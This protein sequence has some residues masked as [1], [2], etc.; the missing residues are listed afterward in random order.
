VNVL[1]SRAATLTAS[2]T[3][4]P[5]QYEASYGGNTQW[6]LEG[7]LRL[8]VARG[9]YLAAGY[10]WEHGASDFLNLTD[11]DARG[12]RLSLGYRRDR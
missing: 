11:L 3:S 1:S 9:F 6:D 5:Q 8:N 2:T 10:R 7:R 4:G 12:L